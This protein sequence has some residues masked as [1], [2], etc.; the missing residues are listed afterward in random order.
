MLLYSSLQQKMKKTPL[1]PRKL[2]K[3]M[4]TMQRNLMTLLERVTLFR[5]SSDYFLFFFNVNTTVQRF[6]VFK[7]YKF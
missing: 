1:Q 5:H 2:L 6:G 7:N 3:E 4:E